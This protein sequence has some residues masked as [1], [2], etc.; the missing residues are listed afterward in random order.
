[1][2]HEQEKSDSAVVAKKPPNK[3]GQPPAGRVEPRPGTKGTEA[4]KARTG[5]RA[6]LA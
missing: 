3:A 2:M 6:G 4:S 1:M 5:H